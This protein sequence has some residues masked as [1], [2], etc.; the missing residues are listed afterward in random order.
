MIVVKY[1]EISRITRTRDE[2]G[3]VLKGIDVN[4]VV[5]RFSDGLAGCERHGGLAS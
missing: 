3:W 4:V 2:I 5:L 1:D